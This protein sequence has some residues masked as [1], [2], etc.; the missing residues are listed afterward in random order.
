MSDQSIF[1]LESEI[2]A[3]KH[4]RGTL[5]VPI[6]PII[7]FVALAAGVILTALG[8]SSLGYPIAALGFFGMLVIIFMKNSMEKWV[9]KIEEQIISAAIELEELQKG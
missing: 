5:T 3:L 2:E 6:S 1:Q 9:Q 8:H 7:P 4:K